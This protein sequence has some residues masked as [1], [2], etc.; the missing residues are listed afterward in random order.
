[1][2]VVLF[3][4]GTYGI[5]RTTC[6]FKRDEFLDLSV[7]LRTKGEMEI[8]SSAA[9]SYKYENQYK[10]K[11]LKIIDSI[12]ALLSI[13]EGKRGAAAFKIKSIVRDLSKQEELEEI[14]WEKETYA[15][16]RRD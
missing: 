7:F 9:E 15:K 1:M 13:P 16:I 5:K 11:Y 2:K 6:L 8:W 12:V 4:D 3:E 14:K 10:T